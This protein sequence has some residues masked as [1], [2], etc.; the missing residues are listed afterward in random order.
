MKV[1]EIL[2]ECEVVYTDEAGNIL[3]ES[4]VRA[5]RRRGKKLVPQYRCT[6]GPRAGMIVSKGSACGHRKDPAKVRMGRKIMRRKSTTI[7]RKGMITRRKPLSKRLVNI[8]RRLSGK[9]LVKTSS[10]TLFS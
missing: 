3:E 4:A 2:Y 5:Y 8:N 7:H 6:S 10:K 1:A 9:S